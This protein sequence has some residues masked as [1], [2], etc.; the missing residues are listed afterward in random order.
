MV[1]AGSFGVFGVTFAVMI[2]LTCAYWMISRGELDIG[3]LVAHLVA[4]GV[5]TMTVHFSELRAATATQ[6]AGRAAAILA[7]PLLA[8]VVLVGMQEF[9]LDR[10][11][12]ESLYMRFLVFYG[13]VFPAYVLL[14]VGPARRWPVT[15][16]HLVMFVIVCLAFMPIYEVGFVHGEM[17]LLL[18]PAAFAAGWI[19]T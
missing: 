12:N 11:D 14:F 17:W 10:K 16:R 6:S 9:E 3:L 19:R 5:F 18:I 1:E 7:A 4:Q 13:L 8:V 2:V 15:R